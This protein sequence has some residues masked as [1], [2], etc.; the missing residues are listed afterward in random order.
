MTILDANLLL[1]AYNA[2][3]PQ[4]SVAARWLSEM[5]ESGENDRAAVDD[6]LGIYSHS[7]ELQNLAQPAVGENKCSRSSRNGLH[8]PALLSCS[9][10]RGIRKFSDASLSNV[11]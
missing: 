7:Y 9:Q 11:A 6:C 10:A 3:A 4:H 2:D 1:Y 8:S 5:L